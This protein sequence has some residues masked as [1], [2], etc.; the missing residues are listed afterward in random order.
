MGTEVPPDLVR[1]LQEDPVLREIF[2]A[3][4]IAMLVVLAL[5]A[6]VFLFAVCA[7]AIVNIPRSIRRRQRRKV[8]QEL[9]AAGTLVPR[10]SI[11]RKN[12]WPPN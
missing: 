2:L 9:I 12:S 11:R 6:L 8:E 7:Y 3:I 10:P 5:L 1:S 4:G